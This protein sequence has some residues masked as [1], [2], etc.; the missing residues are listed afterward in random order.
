MFELVIRSYKDPEYRHSIAKRERKSQ[1]YRIEGGVNVNLN[2][3]EFFTVI[4]AVEE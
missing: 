4:E 3:E 2:H 1:L